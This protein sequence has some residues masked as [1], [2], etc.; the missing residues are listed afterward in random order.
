MIANFD[1]CQHFLS[2]IFVPHLF[3]RDSQNN[4][5]L[6]VFKVKAVLSNEEIQCLYNRKYSGTVDIFATLFY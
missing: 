6:E 1:F 2:I 5:L 3:G 4:D